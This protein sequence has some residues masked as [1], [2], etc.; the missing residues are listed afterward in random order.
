MSHTIVS[1]WFDYACPHSYKGI[2]QLEHSAFDISLEI[3]L[4]PFLSRNYSID[5]DLVQRELE[6]PTD[7]SRRPPLYKPGESIETEPASNRTTSTLA[8]HGATI[9]QG[10]WPRQ[11]VLLGCFK[12]ILGKRN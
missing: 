8:I 9:C 10:D 1:V 3:D 6:I 7:T 12:R 11:R 2:K 5:K 4:K